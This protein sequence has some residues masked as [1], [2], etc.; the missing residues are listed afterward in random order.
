MGALAIS[1]ANLNT[2]ENNMLALN[3]NIR[4]VTS[5]LININGQ[6]AGFNQEV[7]QMKSS[8]QTLEQEIRDFMIEIRGTSLVS[9]AQNDILIKQNDLNKK[10]GNFD[11]IRHQTEG[12]LES[13][14]LN[15]VS[16]KTLGA[17]SEKIL[18]NTPGYYLSY[19]LLAVISW[20]NNDR[21]K[22]YAAL[23]EA[24]KLN[25]EKTSLFIGLV[26]FKLNRTATGI[27]WLKK[28]LELQNPLSLDNNYISLIE[29]LTA[30]DFDEVTSKMLNDHIDKCANEAK[31]P[32]V[33]DAQVK[34]WEEVF[35]QINIE[36]EDGQFPNIMHFTNNYEGIKTSL[37]NAESYY[38]LYFKITG[39]LEN[40]NNIDDKDLSKLI[41]NFIFSYEDEELK[42]KKDI[43][44]DNLI[45]KHR[46]NSKKADEE[47]KNSSISLEK[48]SDFY[49]MMSN[50]L[51][52]RNDVSL[53]TKKIAISYLKDIIKTAINNVI[54]YNEEKM[55]ATV[56]TI[57]DYNGVTTNGS[58][59]NE[60]KELMHKHIRTPYD[61]ALAN[62]SFFDI[63]IILASIGALSGLFLSILL[64]I[65]LG[66]AVILIALILIFYFA[67]KIIKEREQIE[68]EYLEVER[69]YDDALENILAEIVDAHFIIKRAKDNYDYVLEYLDSFNEQNYIGRG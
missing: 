32:E 65:W 29:G 19:A 39:L 42:L 47:F 24:L 62:Y 45:I 27:K 52:E 34:R 66:F 2:I 33:I 61:K 40:V 10:F 28:Y 55:P 60:L 49:S 64:N 37:I 58:N 35:R 53:N 8:M 48:T 59:E 3:N 22:A 69:N 13:I 15:L 51:L 50:I 26:H 11:V 7:G 56:I 68:N 6:M 21:N 38:D 30:N 41:K 4:T 17:E 67:S 57:N 9:N 36:Y 23:N 43:L 1:S 46:G 20:F 54:P 5:D 16:K 14:N 63:K 18:F 25:T 12:L 31:I 44:Q